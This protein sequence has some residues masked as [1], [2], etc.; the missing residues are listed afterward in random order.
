MEEAR[1]TEAAEVAEAVQKKAD[2]ISRVATIVDEQRTYDHTYSE[3]VN[4]PIELPPPVH[5][6]TPQPEDGEEDVLEVD[7]ESSGSDD[8]VFVPVDSSGDNADEDEDANGGDKDKDNPMSQVIMILGRGRR[9]KVKK[10][11]KMSKKAGLE[12]KPDKQA[13]STASGRSSIITA[14]KDDLH[15]LMTQYGGPALD[16]DVDEQLEH[17]MPAVKGKRKCVPQDSIVKIAPV[18]QKPLTK[19]D[20]RGNALKWTLKHPPRSTA[21][22]FTNEIVPLARELLGTLEPWVVLTVPQMQGI[23]NRVYKPWARGW[24]GKTYCAQ[25][26]RRQSMVTKA[27]EAL[28]NVQKGG[29]SDSDSEEEEPTTAG[30]PVK[31]RAFK[32]DTP[33]GIAEFIEW[34]LEVHE[35]SGT[36]AFHWKTWG[37]GKEK[38]ILAEYE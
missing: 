31:A 7:K 21:P 20:Q 25:G 6:V 15:V 27:M 17:P 22:Q 28:I 1:V 35:E 36:M 14:P 9:G 8:D 12:S 19:K 30:A 26:H 11:P 32:F 18:P 10:K 16:D 3:T 38:S 37:D 4:H 24:E 34:A 23:V 2:S 13:A 29:D 33:K 5:C